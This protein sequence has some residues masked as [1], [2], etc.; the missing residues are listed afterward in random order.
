MPPDDPAFVSSADK[1]RT[2]EE[3]RK[4]IVTGAAPDYLGGHVLAWARRNPDDPR[5]PQAL[6]LVVR[7]TRYGCVD[8]ETSKLSRAAFE[9][10]HRRYP[11]SPWTARTK[12]WY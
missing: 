6:H 9:L 4:L 5:V 11:R 2:R 3:W 12:Y 1:A 7:S 10:L 8:A